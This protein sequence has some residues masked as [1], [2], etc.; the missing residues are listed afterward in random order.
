MYI[1]MHIDEQNWPFL[2][3]SLKKNFMYI[4]KNLCIYIH[5]D[6]AKTWTILGES[7]EKINDTSYQNACWLM[8][9]TATT[10][11]FVYMHV[12][13]YICMYLYELSVRACVRVYVRTCWPMCMIATTVG[14]VCMYVSVYICVRVCMHL[15]V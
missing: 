14:H 10:V 12:Y 11:G 3:E 7:F 5:I 1:H 4:Q 8:F 15:R 2:G 13:M 6:A 9:I